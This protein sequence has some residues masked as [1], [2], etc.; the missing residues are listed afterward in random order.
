MYAEFSSIYNN[1]GCIVEKFI[2]LSRST[3]LIMRDEI[4]DRRKFALYSEDCLLSCRENDCS[5]NGCESGKYFHHGLTRMAMFRKVDGSWTT[6][7]E[8]LQV[9]S[10]RM[11]KG[12]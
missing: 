5:L 11:R 9:V 3:V 7:T 12:I 2:S 8:F 10:I 6:N 4:H 1:S